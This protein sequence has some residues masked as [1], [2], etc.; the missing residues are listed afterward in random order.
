MV[1]IVMRNGKVDAVFDNRA[2]AELHR[3]NLTKRW[4][5][6]VIIEKELLSI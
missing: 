5:L 3:A 6:M 2:A 4:N 1:F